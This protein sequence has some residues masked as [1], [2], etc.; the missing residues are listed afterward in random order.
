M[1]SFY[2]ATHYWDL[3]KVFDEFI[4]CEGTPLEIRKANEAV[5]KKQRFHTDLSSI[6]TTWKSTGC[7]FEGGPK[8]TEFG[9]CISVKSEPRKL[10][11]IGEK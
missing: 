6:T 5:S 3:E 4:Q 11:K 10:G 8:Q 9:G 1:Y 2:R 7:A